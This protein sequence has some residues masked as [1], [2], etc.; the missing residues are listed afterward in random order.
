[1]S[2]PQSPI[3]VVLVSDSFLIGD[4]L[5][6]ILAGVPDIEIVGRAGDLEEM[7]VV[8]D[9]LR[10]QSVIM[11]VRSQVVSTAATVTAARRLRNDYPDMGVVVIS[12]RAHDFALEL[13]SGG[14]LGIAFLLDEDLPGVG[15]VL[16]ALRELQMGQTVLDPSVVDSLIRRGN[17]AGIDDLTPREIDVLE[18]LA[19]GLSN[20]A[21]AEQLHISV[22][23]IEKGITAIFL[24]LGPFDQGGSDRRVSAALVYL[25]SQT[26]PFGPVA[27][28]ASRATPVLVLKDMDAL[29]ARTAG[30]HPQSA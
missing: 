27:N 2:P 14:S 5:A 3:T 30:R 13:L 9:E 17:D 23:S 16:G 20:K 11:S 19:H 7:V 28:S 21:I 1:M 12:D 24:K 18:Q 25:R 29:L 4:G 8:V 22:K 10:P 15:A 6:A 26:D